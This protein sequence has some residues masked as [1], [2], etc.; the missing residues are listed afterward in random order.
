MRVRGLVSGGTYDCSGL[1]MRA[2][3]AAGVRLPRTTHAQWAA[4]ERVALADLQPGDLVFWS[5][6]GEPSGIH[7]VGIYAG[8]WMRVHTPR[9]GKGVERVPMWEQGL[10]PYGGRVL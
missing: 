1:V 7:H 10:L 6:N 9:P 8:G 5:S 4:T 2:Y 3:E